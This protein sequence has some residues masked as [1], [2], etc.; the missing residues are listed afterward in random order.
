MTRWMAVLL[1]V[2]A[3]SGATQAFAQ[4]V[5]AGPGSGRHHHHSGR[6]DVLHGSAATTR[7][8]RASATTT[9][10]AQSPSISI[11]SSLSRGK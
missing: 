4:D 2:A 7:R 1:A 11:A 5:A 8:R 3:M 9:W 6:R 10:A